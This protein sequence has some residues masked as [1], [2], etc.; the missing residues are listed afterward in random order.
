MCYEQ[1]TCVTE[2]ETMLSTGDATRNHPDTDL[3]VL[4]GRQTVG[5]L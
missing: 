3:A 5:E 2:E 1:D 4:P